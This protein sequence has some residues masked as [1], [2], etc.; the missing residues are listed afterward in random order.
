ML[1]QKNFDFELEDYLSFKQK[2]NNIIIPECSENKTKTFSALVCFG[3][4]IQWEEKKKG[5]SPL[6]SF[7]SPD[8]KQWDCDTIV[9]EET[10]IPYQRLE[11][12]R[13]CRLTVDTPSWQ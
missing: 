7:L 13:H 4:F 11:E 1:G 2:K 3:V 6:V 10:E 9:F 12:S 8:K 5:A